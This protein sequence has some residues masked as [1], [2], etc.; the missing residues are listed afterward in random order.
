MLEYIDK[1]ELQ[2]NIENDIC[3]Y[4]AHYNKGNYSSPCRV[5]KVSLVYR[6]IALA[7][8]YENI[9]VRPAIKKKKC[10]DCK[11]HTYCGKTKYGNGKFYACKNENRDVKYRIDPYG[12]YYSHQPSRLACKDFVDKDDENIQEAK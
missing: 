11:Y 10:R 7:T 8:V 12:E 9:E 4:C 6:D 5:C 1:N 3:K 2:N